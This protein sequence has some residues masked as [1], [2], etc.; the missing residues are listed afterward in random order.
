MTNL[1]KEQTRNAIN[2]YCVSKGLSKNEFATHAGVSSATLSK[3]ENRKWDDIDLKLWRKLWTKVKTSTPNIYQTTDCA[4]VFKLCD[5]S[6]KNHF[7]TGLI[8]DTGMGKTTALTAYANR[9]NTYFIVFDKTMKP[10]Q[11][12]INLLKE[13]G[14]PFE[15]SIHL[16]VNR[17]ADELNEQDNPQLIIDEAGKITPTMILYL[18]VLRDKTNK[19]CSIILSGM[20]YFKSNLLKF[21]NKQKEGYAEFFRR[22]NLWHSLQGLS[23]SE[24]EYI[25]KQNGIEDQEQLKSLRNKSRFGDLM[26]EIILHQAINDL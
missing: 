19:N 2:D 12:F 6:R 1:Q 4:A 22:I 5:A 18:H 15:G 25:A 11:F 9:K 13:M 24:I 26:N 16:M 3:I 21:S 10:K 23:R 17:I 8:A 14:I 7:M 20:P